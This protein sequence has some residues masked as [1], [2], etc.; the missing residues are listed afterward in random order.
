MMN[1][2]LASR[3]IVS[4][5]GMPQDDDTDYKEDIS[6][7]LV[8]QTDDVIKALVEQSLSQHH[9]V[10]IAYGFNTAYPLRRVLG[11]D[12]YL[13]LCNGYEGEYDI[14][15]RPDGS[16]PTD[17]WFKHNIIGH[18]MSATTAEEKQLAI[19]ALPDGATLVAVNGDGDYDW[20]VADMCALPKT[21]V[22]LFFD[23][24]C[25]IHAGGNGETE[26]F[27]RLLHS[28]PN[29]QSIDYSEYANYDGDNITAI[30]K[31]LGRNVYCHAV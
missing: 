14:E 28:L 9:R 30:A 12:R 1:T 11:D 2:F 8:G 4:N 23:H 6:E 10:T 3:N 13:Y 26:T 25:V 15:R 24:D 7:L 31:T 17:P 19:S 16:E 22:E 27:T 21:V 29:L 20:T 18:L 5:N